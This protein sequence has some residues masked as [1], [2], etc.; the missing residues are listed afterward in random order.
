MNKKS[1]FWLAVLALSVVPA[2]SCMAQEGPGPGPGG[3][4]MGAR[5][6]NPGHPGMAPGMKGDMAQMKMREGFGRPGEG[7]GFLQEQE[8]LT[9]IKKYDAAFGKK[10]EDLKDMAPAKYKM[11]MQMSGKM[12]GMAAME[13]DESVQKD[14]VRAIS[15]EYESKELS[16]SYNKAS[17]AD[18]KAIKD[19]LTPVL[20][21]LFDL[22]TKAQEMRVKHMEGEIAKLKK[23]LE[24]RKINK[25]KIV[26]QRLDQMTGEG[27]GW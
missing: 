5:D 9:M 18:K 15:L 11:I 12:L 6:E 20:S 2:V 17:D 1:I 27:Y 25:A 14:A 4:E 13:Q 3:D 16:L 24:N 21:E 23:N 22:K 7:P 19:K 26:D 10:L 8:A